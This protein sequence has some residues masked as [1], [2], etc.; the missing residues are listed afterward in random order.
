MTTQITAEP[1]VPQVLM[2]RAFAA[3][4]EIVFRAFTDPDLLAQWYGPRNLTMRVDR[5][6]ARDGGVW[7]Y[8][9]RDAEGNEYGFHGVFHGTPSPDGIVQTREFEGAPG[10]VS[11]ETATFEDHGD[12]TVLH[13]NAVYQTVAARDAEIE[14]GMEDGAN[15]SMQRLEE[16]VARLAS[17]R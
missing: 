3:P 4:R 6:E 5:F 16:L 1:G 12:R 15:E 2:T 13:M 17:A 7:R 11:L 8:V 9:H 10:N 14:S